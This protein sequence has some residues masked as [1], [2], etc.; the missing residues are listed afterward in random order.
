MCAAA[1]AAFEHQISVKRIAVLGETT[2]ERR[3]EETDVEP[4]RVQQ[5]DPIDLGWRFS[6]R[7]A[8]R[9]PPHR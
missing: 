5:T 6:E 7:A 1:R 3:L 2:D 9:L 8:A 4:S